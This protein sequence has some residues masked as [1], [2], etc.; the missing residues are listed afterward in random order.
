[1][2]VRPRSVV[3]RAGICE[4]RAMRR[5]LALTLA[6]WLVPG[7]ADAFCGFF[8]GHAG[9]T[10]S[11][12]ATSVVLVRDGTRT[13]LSMRNDYTGPPEDFAMIVPVPVVLRS[14]DVKT[15]PHAI[16]ERLERTTAPRLV[17]YWE[18]DPCS[19]E[20]RGMRPAGTTGAESKYVIDGAS[21]NAPDGGSVRVL[22]RFEVGEYD[23]EVLGAR[24]SL[25]LARWL[26]DHGY[27]LPPGL[28]G[29]LRPYVQAGMK[30]F[31]A[32]V[33]ISRVRR[34]APGRATLSPLRFHYDSDAFSLPIRLGLLSS[35]GVQDLVVHVIARDRYQAANRA[36][37]AIPTNLDVADAALSAFPQFYAALFDRAVAASPGAVVTE[38]AWSMI[39]KCDPCT[40]P[41]PDRE[42]LATLGG[43]VLWNPEHGPPMPLAVN[44]TPTGN[45]SVE[46]DDPFQPTAERAEREAARRR[47]PGKPWRWP[48]ELVLTRLHLRYG[49]ADVGEDLVLQAAEPIAGGDERWGALDPGF[50]V[51]AHNKFQARYAVRHRWTGPVKCFYPRHGVWSGQPG[52]RPAV[53]TD[54]AFV[55]RDA[56]LATF[57]AGELA[58]AEAL[59]PAARRPRPAVAPQPTPTGCARCDV[60]PG[61][62]LALLLLLR[63]RRRR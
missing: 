1:M 62:S 37:V 18:A 22:S 32:K 2:R 19:E 38:Y 59:A 14:A 13:V 39:Q 41:S 11:N 63:R 60:G 50:R 52:T 53:A 10:L 16:F 47:V 33:A 21:V 15:L 36:N 30:F 45:V 28:D 35:D 23:V 43:D 17:E 54:L 24:D 5:I 26:Q 49:A 56:N 44:H 48:E 8:V 46:G 20:T 34:D 4:P 27:K 7:E 25:G 12:R 57:L 42:M 29:A 31:A 40:A 3:V 9:S 51:A 55:P 58:P 6:A 61:G